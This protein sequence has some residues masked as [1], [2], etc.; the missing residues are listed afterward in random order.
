VTVEGLTKGDGVMEVP[1]LRPGRYVELATGDP[2]HYF[3]VGAY[4][5]L[6][7]ERSP[8]ALARLLRARSRGQSVDVGLRST[9]CMS[10]L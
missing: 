6:H 8:E 4:G 1:S 3:A 2:P 10:A 7:I 9:I 5:T